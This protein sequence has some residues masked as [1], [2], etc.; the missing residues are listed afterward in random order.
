MEHVSKILKG[1]VGSDYSGDF[2]KQCKSHE[3]VWIFSYIL[4][5]KSVY[6]SVYYGA[7]EW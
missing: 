4:I 2:K 6:Y 1:T 5:N 7:L 3:E